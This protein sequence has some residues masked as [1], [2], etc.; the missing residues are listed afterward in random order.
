MAS[1]QL[2]WHKRRTF[3][4][5]IAYSLVALCA[6][7]AFSQTELYAYRTYAWIAMSMLFLIIPC[8]CTDRGEW[9]IGY[10]VIFVSMALFLLPILTFFQMRHLFGKGLY[11]EDMAQ[12]LATFTS[13]LLFVFAALRRSRLFVS[14]Q[15]ITED[16]VAGTSDTGELIDSLQAEEPRIVQIQGWLIL[17]AIA[18]GVGALYGVYDLVAFS[19]L[20][21]D[22][23][24]L[25]SDIAAVEYGGLFALGLVV[26]IGLLGF[27]IYAA[28]NFYRT[29]RNAPTTIIALLIARVLVEGLLSVVEAFAGAEELAIESVGEVLENVVGAVIGIPYFKVSKRVKATFIN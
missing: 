6:P 15:H 27:W 11:S 22:F 8:M 10:R 12:I 5:V 14:P 20:V 7:Y 24:M 21:S 29:K 28:S 9:G 26:R 23:S 2:K 17:P 18:L 19:M 16:R 13:S 4:T 1:T 25:V 3:L